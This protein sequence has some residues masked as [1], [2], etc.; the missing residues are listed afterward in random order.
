MAEPTAGQRK[1]LYGLFALALLI[2]VL[3]F[4]AVAVLSGML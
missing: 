1:L 2:A 4:V 3:G